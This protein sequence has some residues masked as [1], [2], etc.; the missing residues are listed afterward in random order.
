VARSQQSPPKGSSSRLPLAIGAVVAIG[1]GAFGALRL[2]PRPDAAPPL[3]LTQAALSVQAPPPEP[4]P[5]SAA[6]A[7][8]SNERTVKVTIAPADATVEVNGKPATLDGGAIEIM[9]AL[10][11]VHRV[12]V[13]AGSAEVRK[14][15]VVTDSGALPSKIELAPAKDT[16][17]A[18][19]AS[20]RG[21][22][23]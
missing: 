20:A 22:R 5:P 16:K 17:P 8:A 4:P 2:L 3:E 11:S 7:P 21:A 12:R 9:G 14:D 6:P 15:V 13:T 23:R 18:A 1:A 10:G 19:S